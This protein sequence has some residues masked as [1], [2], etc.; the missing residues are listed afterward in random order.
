MNP[1]FCWS[2]MKSTKAKS[3]FCFVFY[4]P[5]SNHEQTSVTI[6]IVIMIIMIAII[7]G[8]IT[9]WTWVCTGKEVFCFSFTP[10][11]KQEKIDSQE[12][13]NVEISFK[14]CRRDAV[15]DVVCQPNEASSQ[16]ESCLWLAKAVSWFFGQL[17]VCWRKFFDKNF[18]LF[19]NLELILSFQFWQ[20]C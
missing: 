8:S 5:T 16:V 4:V 18:V 20:S 17:E 14:G 3:T 12:M 11:M 10:K 9:W 15:V 6:A 2:K 1:F 7:I 13:T 19:L